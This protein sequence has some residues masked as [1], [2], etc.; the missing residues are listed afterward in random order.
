MLAV[1]ANWCLLDY[2]WNLT[3]TE[4][5]TENTSVPLYNGKVLVGQ[6]NVV[7]VWTCKERGTNDVTNCIWVS[8]GWATLFNRRSIYPLIWTL[9]RH[10]Q[11]FQHH[12]CPTT[13]NFCNPNKN[14]EIKCLIKE[15][16]TAK[17]EVK[18]CVLK[19]HTITLQ[20]L[21]FQISPSDYSYFRQNSVKYRYDFSTP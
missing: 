7:R 5:S 9:F 18:S 17:I 20:N 21:C 6:L 4:S 14:Q 11:I 1:K 12:T 15:L 19:A 13:S 2:K 8:T 16:K 3:T 10:S